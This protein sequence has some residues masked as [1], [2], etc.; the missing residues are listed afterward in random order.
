MSGLKLAPIIVVPLIVAGGAFLGWMAQLFPAHVPLL[1]AIGLI[2]L[3]V[4][5]AVLA[6]LWV[7]SQSPKASASDIL[8]KTG[9][10]TEL[11]TVTGWY[12][13]QW[14]PPDP[15][16][17]LV[18]VDVAQTKAGTRRRWAY[19]ASAESEFLP[20]DSDGRALWSPR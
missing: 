16:P 10:T 13:V 7:A 20:L 12:W 3:L 8:P 15:V 1:R 5:A 4:I 9:W 19:D 2:G 14:S 17:D 11:P 18:Y 6:V